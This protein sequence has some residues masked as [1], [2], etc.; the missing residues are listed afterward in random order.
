MQQYQ[1]DAKM[2]GE[3]SPVGDT[4]EMEICSRFIQTIESVPSRVTDH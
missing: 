1:G 4:P 3:M 2:F